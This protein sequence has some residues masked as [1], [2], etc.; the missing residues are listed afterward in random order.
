MQRLRL[1]ILALIPL[2]ISTVTMAGETPVM[3]M[4][5]SDEQRPEHGCN[6]VEKVC[7]LVYDAVLNKQVKLWDSPEKELQILPNALREIEKNSPVS[8][9]GLETIFIYEI[10]EQKR[11]EVLTKTIGISFT[12]R[13]DDPSNSVTFGYVDYAD[14]DQLF[15]KNKI[16]TNANGVYSSTFK[17]YIL[18][19]NYSF[20]LVQFNGVLV[21]SPSESA[22]IVKSFTKGFP[23][24][25]S[26]LGFYP[27]DKYV[28]L[29]MDTYSE[30]GDS[31]AYF[32]KYVDAAIETYFLENKEVF[33]NLG[34]DKI[35]DH[36]EQEK[37]KVTRV[38]FNEIWRIIGGELNFDTQGMVV[39]INDEPMNEIPY[40]QLRE[41]DIMIAGHGLSDLIK[42]RR[43]NFIITQVN[44][45]DIKNH[46]SY[47]YQK[48]L[49]SGNWDNVIEYVL[50]F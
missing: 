44:S 33:F 5:R 2:C 22:E 46:D 28:S 32:S 17:S 16:E 29:I 20:N 12:N 15:L 23:Y 24:N 18:S 47:L 40:R 30:S 11:K 13:T 19:H 37:L 39:Y 10:W 1:I 4:L 31:M 9:G 26:A 48:A 34:G 7:E 49:L 3:M 8:F 14:L 27:P 43:F 36:I 6:F 45:Q 50:N 35:F 21:K 25:R 38:Q 42:E 41:M